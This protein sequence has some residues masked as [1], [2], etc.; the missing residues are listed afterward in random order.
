MLTHSKSPKHIV[1]NAISKRQVQFQRN[2]DWKVNMIKSICAWTKIF[3]ILE[4]HILNLKSVFQMSKI[5][6]K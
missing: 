5:H 1:E 6:Q 2:L 3:L 4:E